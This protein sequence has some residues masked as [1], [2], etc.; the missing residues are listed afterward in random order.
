MPALVH[1][2]RRSGVRH[3]P[4][5]SG[6]SADKQAWPG[7]NPPLRLCFRQQRSCHSRKYTPAAGSRAIAERAPEHPSTRNKQEDGPD[8]AIR[9][10]SIAVRRFET[11]LVDVSNAIPVVPHGVRTVV[12]SHDGATRSGDACGGQAAKH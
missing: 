1:R 11:S 3:A 10:I 7:K 6:G 8:P 12:V 2:D 5:G 4:N 9:F